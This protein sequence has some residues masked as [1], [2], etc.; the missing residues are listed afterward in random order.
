MCIAYFFITLTNDTSIHF[1]EPTH[2]K[3][4]LLQMNW[5]QASQ[6]SF[7]CLVLSVLVRSFV[8]VNVL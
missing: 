1:I 5:F 8:I 7:G 2:K 6:L 3:F 4:I